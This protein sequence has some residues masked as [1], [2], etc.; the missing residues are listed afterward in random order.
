MSK[1]VGFAVLAAG[2]GTRLK[3]N[4][5]KPMAPLCG[6]KLV[7]FP[8][9]AALDFLQDKQGKIS[10]ITGHRREEVES[11]L[12]S[13]YENIEF[14]FQEKQLGTGD[15]LKSYFANSSV[16]E[17]MDYTVVICADTPLIRSEHLD[18]LL[19]ELESDNRE[20][21]AAI[22]QTNKPEGYGRIICGNPGFHI[23][24]EKD[25][26]DE[27]KAVNWVNSGLYIF[28]TNYLKNH[29]ND[30]SSNNKANEFYLTDLF[31]DDRNV[32]AVSFKDDSTFL[33]VNDQIQLSQA[34]HLIRREINN[35]HL[36]AG[37]R[38]IDPRHTFID[39]DVK[40][41]E[42]S[43]IY[44]NCHIF[45]GCHLGSGVEVEPGCI[46]KNTSI[47]DG[48]HL[49]AYSYFEDA[50]VRKKA[51]IGPFARIRP[52]SDIGEESKIGNFVETKKVHLDK[53][54]K[55]SHL[56][57]VG[58]AQVGENTN[59]GCG[60][61]TCNYDGANKHKTIIGKN[62]FIGSDSQMIA[63]VNIGNE[64]YIGSGSTINQDVPDGGFA[65]AR[66]RQV[67]KEGMAKKFI[68]KKK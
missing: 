48:V 55:V 16:A 53:G 13:N 26:T 58:D 29:L 14:C 4:L 44:P 38:V 37:V 63:P 59:I 54:V 22:F 23:V 11:Y 7:D 25:A 27:Q 30:L 49:K 2:E 52:G 47:E 50:I 8:M 1:K 36:A 24:E 15:A 5:A 61:I 45:E 42:G 39:Y 3:M 35:R 28:K 18:E 6:K 20:A 57:Y 67:T 60:F 40:I 12:S 32:K 56:S 46:L 64:A 33:G 43:V 34:E 19:V 68:K 31:Q 41:G 51:V 65:I 62:S 17:T 9:M 66:A 10:I 21:V